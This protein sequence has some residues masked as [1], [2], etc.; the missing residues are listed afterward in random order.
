MTSPSQR[1]R[2]NCPVCGGASKLH[3]DFKR[4]S[5]GDWG[6]L[7][8]CYSCR[9]HYGRGFLAELSAATGIP[10]WR[11]LEGPDDLGE[12]VNQ[13]SSHKPLEALPTQRDIRYWHKQLAGSRSLRSHLRRER[14][15]ALP[16]LRRY[17]IGYDGSAFTIPIYDEWGALVNLKR[18]YWPDPWTTSTDAVWKRSLGG[19]GAQLFPDLP[20]NKTLLLVA[21]EFDA[22]VTRQHRLPSGRPLPVATTTCGATLP[23]S[24]VPRFAG[25]CVAVV[26]DAGELQQAAQTVG[27]LE[28]AGAHAWAVDLREAGLS[29]KE[30]LV[31]WFRSG[32]TAEQLRHLA[33]SACLRQSSRKGCRHG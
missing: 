27:K 32:R 20:A 24:L 22:L 30:D 28:A 7:Y 15:L 21:G 26:Y 4:L 11:L 8:G 29:P 33:V 10:Q 6:W 9:Q 23:A 12:P 19:R 2:F 1:L 18:R 31:D 3:A 17:Q 16:T 25:R 14:G 5:R 13:I